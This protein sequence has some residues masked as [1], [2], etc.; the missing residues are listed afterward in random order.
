MEYLENR[1]FDEIQIGDSATLTR[2]L[3]EQDIMLFAVMSGDINPAHVD[4]DY[5][6]NSQFREVIGHGMWS[7]A[8]ISTVLGTQFPGPGTI[9]LGQDLRFRHPVGVGDTVTVKVTAT[10][11]NAEKGRLTLET[12][13]VNQD[14]KVVVSGTAH[15]IAPREKVR[16]PRI[17][18]PDVRIDDRETR[19]RQ[20]AARVKGRKLDPVCT[21]VAHPCDIESLAGALE[22]GREGVIIPVLVGPEDRLRETARLAELDL[23]GVTIVPVAHS[24]EAA[25]VAVQLA[26]EGKVEAIMK[27]SLRTAELIEAVI[28]RDS[29]LRTE[30]RLSH[31]FAMDVPTYPKALFITDGVINI[32]PTLEEKRD[33]VQN[34]IDLVH[35]L[36]I[37]MPRVAILAAM[38]TVNPRMRATIEAAVL[39]KMADRGQI[40]G[41]VLEGPLGF[42]N[43]ISLD[44]ARAGH[45]LSPVA[46]QADILVVPDIESG[47]MLVKQLTYLADALAA[48]IVLGAR[49]PI[50][51]P[52]RADDRLSRMASAMLMQIAARGG[53]SSHERPA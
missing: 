31:L 15:V 9:Y 32:E 45:I 13:C 28:A 43:A 18:L 40:T 6:K 14:G 26:R 29:G 48:G 37:T 39:C 22:A 51:V 53:A 2:T 23:A 35:S 19:F 24:H 3:T 20:I 17:D 34:A 4:P 46:G 10:E 38:E 42:D 5:A 33:I 27:G 7:G 49:V 1:T 16:R 41:A 21:A 52:N 44:A 50:V 30:R 47:N 11:R 12:E 25:A 8:L 36:G